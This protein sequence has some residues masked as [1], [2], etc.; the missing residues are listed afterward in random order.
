[1]SYIMEEGEEHEG[2]HGVVGHHLSKRSRRNKGLVVVFDP[3][4]RKQFVTGF[5]KRKKQRRKYAEK[6]KIIKDREKRLQER[7]E[8]RLAMKSALRESGSGEVDVEEPDEAGD[9]ICV[10][11]SQI[12]QAHLEKGT[13]VYED[14]NTTTIVNTCCINLNDDLDLHGAFE[15][16]KSSKLDGPT[17]TQRVSSKKLLFGKTQKKGRA[18]IKRGK[19]G[20]K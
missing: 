9:E 20:S 15:K 12:N 8:R 14:E 2:G 1:M 4:D 16:P 7:K 11:P 19:S 10:D 17:Q 3:D 5:H 6:Q 13:V 18:L